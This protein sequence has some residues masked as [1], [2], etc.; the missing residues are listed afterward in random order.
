MS[1]PST[2]TIADGD[3]LVYSNV[4]PATVNL[5]GEEVTIWANNNY[6]VS[7]AS[8]WREISEYTITYYQTQHK[9][10]TTLNLNN[11]HTLDYYAPY[12]YIAFPEDAVID[13]ETVT[14]F[15]LDND[16][17]PEPENQLRCHGWRGACNTH[18]NQC[19]NGA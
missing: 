19:V 10:T 6:S 2:S 17:L 7:R 8:V 18:P 4:L 14:L 13:Q 3:N 9:W 15:D 12:W 16:I 5:D 1:L 11:S